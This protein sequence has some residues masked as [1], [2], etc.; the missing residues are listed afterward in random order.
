M[1]RVTSK[2]QV[3]IP[4][5]VAKA[6]AIVPGTEIEFQPAG[7]SIRVY[8]PESSPVA[9]VGD[10]VSRR[11]EQFDAAVKRQRQRDPEV[12]AAL[13]NDGAVKER[14]WTREELYDRGVS[15]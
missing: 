5:A 15:C 1:S 4:K 13:G 14:G 3:T 10:V 2:L 9:V 6:Y 11:L 7:E 8:L 12:L